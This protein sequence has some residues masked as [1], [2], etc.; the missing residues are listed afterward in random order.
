MNYGLTQLTQGKL[1]V[2]RTYFERAAL[3][4]PNYS[5]LEINLGIVYASLG[6]KQRPEQHF[7]RALELSNDA[8]SNFYYAR[9]LVKEGRTPEAIPHLERAVQLSPAGPF[10]RELLM[11]A[12]AARGSTS[13]LNHL[14]RQTLNITPED[15]TALAYANG[16]FPPGLKARDYQTLFQFGVGAAR[17]GDHLDG[18]Q[19]MR[20]ALEIDPRSAD[21]WNNLG[22]SLGNL[23][24]HSEAASAFGKALEIKPDY[25]LAKNNL[26]WVV[27]LMTKTSK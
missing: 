11:K 22:W 15:K 7:K 1:E 4:N 10:A 20:K 5:T 12:Y 23:G 6:D 27:G 9:W 25:A 19:A 21:A 8:S 24:F 16:E 17:L 14:V 26:G 13:E 2:A 18:A 3:L